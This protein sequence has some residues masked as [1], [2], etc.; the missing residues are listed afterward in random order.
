MTISTQLSV[1]RLLLLCGANSWPC[2]MAA[3]ADPKSCSTVA[4][5]SRRGTPALHHPVSGWL[6]DTGAA[7][8]AELVMASA[9]DS[10]AGSGPEDPSPRASP[11]L[12]PGVREPLLVDMGRGWYLAEPELG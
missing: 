10:E 7:A 11:V 5:T 3:P 12:S 4:L 9:S 6:A 1:T 2:P 8:A